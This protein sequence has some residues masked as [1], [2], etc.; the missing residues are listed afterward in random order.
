MN[1]RDERR[2]WDLQFKFSDVIADF[3]FWS[4]WRDKA[5]LE[6]GRNVPF[7]RVP[8]GD[9][10]RQWVEIAD[11]GGSGGQLVPVFLHGGYWRALTA[12]GHRC[13]MTGLSAFGPK[14]GNVEYRLMPDFRLADL[15]SDATAAVTA[16]AG[17]FPES[18]KLLLVGHSAGA[19]LAVSAALNPGLAGRIAGV[20]AMSGVYDLAP[21]ARSFLQDEIGLTE[22]EISTHSLIGKQPGTPLICVVGGRETDEFQSQSR[23]MAESVGAAHLRV[24]GAHHMNILSDLNSAKSPL[25]EALG[26]WLNNAGLPEEVDTIAK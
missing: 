7:E 19:H 23:K 21:V 3:A 25:I 15:V 5:S 2:D 18:S 26:L 14:C 20:V 10:D 1:D 12:E 4:D 13:C 6:V 11:C 17:I 22:E 9:H 24:R 16:L 8:Y